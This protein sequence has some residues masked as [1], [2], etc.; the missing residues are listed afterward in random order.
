MEIF[1]NIIYVNL[2]LVLRILSISELYNLIV[3]TDFYDAMP[4]LAA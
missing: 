4:S 1:L 2:K 3:L